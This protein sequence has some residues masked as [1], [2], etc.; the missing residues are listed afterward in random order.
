MN[1]TK[2][3]LNWKVVPIAS[4]ETHVWLKEIHYARRIP[5]ISYAFGMYIDDELIGVVTYG[6][7]ASSSLKTGVAG[8]QNK[9][10]VL[11]LNR[12][13][14]KTPVKNASSFLVS[15]SLA[16]LPK[17]NIVVSYADMGQGHVGYVY[18]ACNFLYTG[19]SAKRTD[20]KV[21]GMEH[22]HGQTIADRSRHIDNSVRG[23]RAQ[24]M[25]DTYGDD[26]YL[27]ERSRKH[28]YIY[29]LGNK[30]QK[31]TLLAQL[32]YKIEPYPKGDTQRYEIEATSIPVAPTIFEW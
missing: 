29:I 7:P 24:Y 26:F 21:K 19:L 11:E 23:S 8:A 4:K 2:L 17:P 16:M 13:C 30:Q 20:W 27:K 14:L 10:I 22:L 12:L 25:R 28:R 3:A 15:R 31:K 32:K 6:T 18:Q 1:I 5:S 9:G